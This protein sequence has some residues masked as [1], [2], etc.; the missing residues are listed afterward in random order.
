MLTAAWHMRTTG[1]DYTDLGADHYTRR[2]GDPVR[3]TA[4]LLTQLEELGYR[5]TL[6]P[7]G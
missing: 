3:R 6:D 5:V 2:C 4:K 1:T 7:A